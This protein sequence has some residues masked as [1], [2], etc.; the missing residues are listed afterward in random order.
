MGQVHYDNSLKNDDL[1]NYLNKINNDN[2]NQN[3]N[4]IYGYN[5]A[6]ASS[7]KIKTRTKVLEQHVHKKGESK[8]SNN[9]KQKHFNIIKSYTFSFYENNTKGIFLLNL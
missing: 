8:I 4:L 7:F 2:N 5:N 3:E 6:N 1:K 9:G